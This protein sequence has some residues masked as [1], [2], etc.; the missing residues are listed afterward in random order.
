MRLLVIGLDGATF[1]LIKP[2]TAQE[3]LPTLKMLMENGVHSDLISTIPPVSS[4]AWPSFMT[5]KNPGKHGIF[6]FVGRSDGYS[7]EIR[8]ASDIKAKTFWK[9]LSEEG[10]MCIVVNVPVTYPPEEIKGCITTGMLT[11]PNACYVYPPE[12]YEELKKICY[13][14]SVEG[15]E[16]RRKTSPE[17]ILDYLVG[18]ASRRVEAV[19]YLMKKFDWDFCMIVFSGTDAIQ[20]NLWQ[21]HRKKILQYYKKVDTLIKELINKAGSKTNIILISDH[22]FGPVYKAFHINYFLHKLGLLEFK[23]EGRSGDYV[24]VKDYRSAKGKLE[25]ILFKLGITK[26]IVYTTAKKMHMLWILQK[27]YKKLYIKIPTT[28]KAIDWKKTKVFYNSTIGPAP[29]LE[30]NLEGREPEGIVKKEE[31]AKLREFIISELLKVKDPETGRK[32]VQDAFRRG[33]IYHGPYVSEA[34]DITFLTNNFEYSATERVYGDSLVSEPVHKGRGAH[35]MNGIFIAY[36]PDIKNTGE[37][38]KKAR[39]IDLAPT[40]LHMF[41]LEVPEDMD[42]KVLTYIFKPDSPIAK[43]PKKYRKITEKERVRKRIRRLKKLQ[44]KVTRRNIY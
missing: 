32:I 24:K 1:D 31:Y 12:I 7:R 36:G 3:E 40:I 42:G 17:Q 13:I 8:N 16:I 18:V 19:F 21:H 28:K 43:R 11:P 26:E 39:I 33:D 34:P 14:P 5:G 27:M 10:K 29:S 25:R 37:E 23:T 9:L 30:I 20:H 38:L 6:D 44:R 4:P 22:G 15:E 35:R 2:W 41:S